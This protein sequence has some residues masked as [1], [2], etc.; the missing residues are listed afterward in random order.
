MIL[1]LIVFII[2]LIR[3]LFRLNPQFDLVK[4]NNKYSLLL[5]YSKYDLHDNCERTYIKLF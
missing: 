4:C 5:W 1:I 2:A 3:I